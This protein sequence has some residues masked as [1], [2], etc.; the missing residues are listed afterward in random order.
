[1]IVMH[2]LGTLDR[3]GAETVA[4]DLCRAV[5]ADEFQQVF[6]TLGGR[7]GRLADLFRAAGALVH[8]CPLRPVPTFVPRLWYRLRETRPHVVVSHVST[9]SGLMLAVAAAAGVA[10][11]IAN[12]HSDSDGRPDTMRRRAQRAVL[13]ALLRRY[14][15][16]VVGVSTTAIAYASPR[17]GDQRYGVVP[18]GIDVERFARV[19]LRQDRAGPAVLT[20]V[21]RAAREK[22]RAFLLGVHDAA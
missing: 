9:A 5:P 20:H 8:Q 21:G 11:R 1:M 7:E 17:E 18:N 14:A 2:L 3:G 16:Q 13:R 15:T 22:N 4:L 19:R 12:M 6:L 10:V